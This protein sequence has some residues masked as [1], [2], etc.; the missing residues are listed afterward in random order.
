[1]N[2]PRVFAITSLISVSWFSA[3]AST[4]IAPAD[5]PAITDQMYRDAA[6]PYTSVGE[7]K[8][9]GLSG[10]GVLIGDRWVLTAGHIASGKSSGGTFILGGTTYTVTTAVVH[11]SYSASGP[12]YDIGLLYLS[13]AVT[14]VD[15][16]VM[17]DFGDPSSILG[18]E[19]TWTGYGMG[20][21]GLT[22]YPGPFAF[23][24][25]TNV[26][27]V[28]G[29]H[30]DYEGLPATAFV[31]DF[32]RPGDS[33]KN[34]PG[35]N[36]NPTDLEGNVAP[37]DSGGGVFV[38]EGGVSY[39]VGISSYTGYLDSNPSGSLSRY[40]GLSGGTNLE[41]FHSWIYDRTGIAAVPEP[42]TA[43]LVALTALIP[44]L[45]RRRVSA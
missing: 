43:G 42:G 29:D 37:G 40:G 10:S 23:R 5:N 22:G 36:P 24:A 21:T 15:P 17:Y 4:I 32:D 45:R 13:S 2:L 19:A 33:T 27:D 11:P 7:V 38:K 14:G 6:L 30:P 41:L 8:G 18:K 1:M 9:S 31:S 34:A 35:S 16:A 12:L 20:G 26:I 3:E 28:M 44:L 39:L 25:F